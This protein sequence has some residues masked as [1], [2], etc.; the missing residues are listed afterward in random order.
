MSCLDRL[1]NE[2]DVEYHRR[3]LYGKLIDK[4]IDLDYAELSPYLY[5]KKY[6]EDVARRMAYGSV[7]TLKLLED[8]KVQQ[9]L[10]EADRDIIDELERQQ[11]ELA[12]ERQRFYDQRRE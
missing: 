11:L 8:E 2:T 9:K 10:S 6:A 5:G 1:P 7:R 3:L 4:S 12:K